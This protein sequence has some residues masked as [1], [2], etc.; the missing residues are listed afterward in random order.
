MDVV[1]RL[2]PSPSIQLRKADRT[3][4]CK[5]PAPCVVQ[6]VAHAKNMHWITARHPQALLT[7]SQNWPYLSPAMK[8]LFCVL[9]DLLHAQGACNGP[10][11]S[12]D[13]QSLHTAA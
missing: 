9:C 2:I 11:A 4:S 12:P 8:R 1:R 3:P 7:T 13:P 5:M 10:S 6:H